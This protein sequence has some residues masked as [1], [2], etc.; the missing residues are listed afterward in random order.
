[1]RAPPFFGALHALAVDDGGGGR[2]FALGVLATFDVERVMNAVEDAA[3]API[4]KVAIHCA[5][6][7]KILGDIAPLAA[8]AQHI[9]DTVEDFS[10]VGFALAPATLGGR[11][12]RRH[13]RPFLIRHV[14]RIAQMIPLYF[15]RFS[16][17][18]ISGPHESDRYP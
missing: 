6:R 4:A 16:F 11:N 14:A 9:H 13:M 1:M 17:V 8:R 7:R 2:G 12:E 18:H 15:E 5:F 3:P 10:H